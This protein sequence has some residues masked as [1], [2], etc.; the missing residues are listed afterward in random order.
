MIIFEAFGN[1]WAENCVKSA[2]LVNFGQNKD[3]GNEEN[4]SKCVS[5]GLSWVTG[6]IWDQNWCLAR[7][8]SS[9]FLRNGHLTSLQ[10]HWKILLSF[11]M[12]LDPR[13]RRFRHKNTP[14]CFISGLCFAQ[15]NQ[16]C[17]IYVIF[18]KYLPTNLVRSYL[19]LTHLLKIVKSTVLNQ[20]FESDNEQDWSWKLE[21]C[22]IQYIRFED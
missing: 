2:F 11:R 12:T 8:T 1:F 15:T 5:K 17:I 6:S 22:S 14:D 20:Y 16:K 9:N 7:E 4:A 21:S 19:K 18:K 13:A 3:T 10:T